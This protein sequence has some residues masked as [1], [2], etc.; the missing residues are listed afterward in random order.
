[1]KE[2]QCWVKLDKKNTEK[3]KMAKKMLNF[4]ASKCGV[5]RGNSGHT[6]A[7]KLNLTSLIYRKTQIRVNVL[8]VAD[9]FF[10]HVNKL[11]TLKGQISLWSTGQ[12]SLWF[13]GQICY[14]LLCVWMLINNSR[15]RWMNSSF[16]RV[17]IFP[18]KKRRKILVIVTSS[19]N[20]M[21]HEF[22]K[23]RLQYLSRPN[24]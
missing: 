18:S 23:S 17:K 2:M 19:I 7:H 24:E 5:G 1:M 15:A 14:H 13:T 21:Q 20:L 10:H 12:I 22:S 8:A 4:G 16:V 6:L 3:F 11:K 9:I